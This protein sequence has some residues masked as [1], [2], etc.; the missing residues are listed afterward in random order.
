VPFGREDASLMK[1]A[2]AHCGTLRF[3]DLQSKSTSYK[4]LVLCFIF[5]KQMLHEVRRKDEKR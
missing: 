1:C 5:A 2:A 4:T 3:I